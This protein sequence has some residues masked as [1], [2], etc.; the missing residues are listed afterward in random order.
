M[1]QQRRIEITAFR[2]R[3]TIVLRESAEVV[4]TR[5]VSPGENASQLVHADPT[6]VPA[7]DLD[8]PQNG[9]ARLDRGCKA[10]D[11]KSI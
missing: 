5:T 9:P 10:K 4:P 11:R 2:R 3:T 1:K 8:L 7:C 6:P